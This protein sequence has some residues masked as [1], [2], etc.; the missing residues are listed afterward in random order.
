MHMVTPEDLSAPMRPP[1]PTQWDQR[2]SDLQSARYL[3]LTEQH[4]EIVN[5]WRKAHMHDEID[6]SLGPSDLSANPLAEICRQLSTPGLYGRMPTTRHADAGGAPLIGPDGAL[7]RAGYWSRM[8]RV[9]YFA[10]GMGEQP[11]R[12]DVA[13][14]GQLTVRMP[15]PSDLYVVPDEERPDQARI[16]WE[17][18][19]R[20]IP[21]QPRKARYVWEQYSIPGAS[22]DGEPYFRIVEATQS[23]PG[24]DV[25]ADYLRNA[26]GVHVPL[27]GDA[28]PYR[29]AD[30]TPFLPWVFYRA[31][32]TGQFWNHLDRRG[33]HHGTLM[34]SLFYTLASHTAHSASGDMA[35]AWG[36]EP[37]GDVERQPDGTKR[38]VTNRS[39][40]IQPRTIVFT[41]Q[42]DEALQPNIK[43]L[44]AGGN[45]D[46]LSAWT[47]E[48]EM[49]QAMRWGLSPADVTR[50][51]ANPT[52][53]AALAISR[54]DKRE[55]MEQV[56]EVF[57]RADVEAMGK[58]AALLRAGGDTRYAGLP[59][60]GYTISYQRIS[61]S[62]QE[63]AARRD[64]ID[65]QVKNGHISELDAYCLLHPGA[66]KEDALVARTMVQV[67]QALLAAHVEN[68]LKEAGL[69]RPPEPRHE[70][71]DH[72]ADPAEE[73]TP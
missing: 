7:V 67:D 16:V 20:S 60:S 48:Y 22:G 35:I 31:Q 59:D 71:P 73:P 72:P 46:A 23:G 15:L 55:A 69:R 68:G 52:S 62:P 29:Y 53:G 1:M 58:A 17:L 18:R 4:D 19:L 43:E 13:R 49:R 40:R 44:S 27:E 56:E 61:E 33:V 9:Q 28:Y 66:T 25:S 6:D 11:V 38:A 36:L 37:I 65:W 30:G 24:A 50:Q 47:R 2:R 26:D 3:I 70:N 57:R 12:L 54:T 32:D 14:D 8:Q 42:T 10:L 41:R 34:T 64:D 21:G 45:L 51:H 39:L 63:A 5:A